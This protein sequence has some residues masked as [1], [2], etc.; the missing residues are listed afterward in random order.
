MSESGRLPSRASTSGRRLPAWLLVLLVGGGVLLLDRIPARARWEIVDTDTPPTA[1]PSSPAHPQPLSPLSTPSPTGVPLPDE[2]RVPILMYHYVS[3]LPENADIYRRDLTVSPAD[4]GEQLQYLAD[5]G[6][7]PISLSDI[8]LY[9]TRGIPLPEKPVVLSFDDGYVDAYEIV[10]PLLLEYGFT[11]T[12]FVLATPAHLASPHYL[13]WDQMKEMS[14]AGMDIEGHGRDHINLTLEAYES[15]VYQILGVREAVE[16]HTGRAPLFF[17]YPSGCYDD[18]VIAVVEGAGYWGAVT[19][20]WGWT[21]TLD[22]A[23]VMPRIR[24]RGADTLAD[25]VHKLE[26]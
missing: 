13:T 10:F 25:F 22:G 15:L 5:E 23:Y 19:T 20:E 1:E 9:L 21:H 14:E 26:G 12:F 3:E 11:G 16:A 6:Y 8:H 7:H 4:F 17:C 24:M 2:A 18:D